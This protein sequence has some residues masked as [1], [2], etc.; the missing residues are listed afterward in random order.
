MTDL[1]SWLEEWVEV[2]PDWRISSSAVEL[3]FGSGSPSLTIRGKELANWMDGQLPR[4]AG[5]TYVAHCGIE[6]PGFAEYLIDVEH[7]GQWDRESPLTFKVGKTTV[8]LSAISAGVAALLEP[9]Y[10]YKH[11]YQ[12]EFYENYST[13]QLLGSQSP[14]VDAVA[15]LYY[16]NSDYLR[17][18]KASATIVHLVDPK[19]P[20]PWEA[21]QPR[22]I[23]RYRIRTRPQLAALI[24]G[25]LYVGAAAEYGDARFLG[26]YRVLEF[27]F[28]R[29]RVA[30]LSRARRDF[31]VSDEAFLKSV[32]DLHGELAEL[33]SLLRSVLSS[34]ECG[35]LCRYLSHHR[36]ANCSTAD[37]LAK[38][39]YAHRNALVHA[40]ENRSE[41]KVVP[42]LFAPNKSTERWSWVVE[43]LADR[44]IRKLGTVRAL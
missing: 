1:A 29:A 17:A 20:A 27:F 7:L 26:F 19:E 12:Y 42:D 3:S 35:K 16:L 28:N 25:Q 34:A 22:P 23:R 18:A 14:R 10:R 21:F 15:A 32:R 33:S 11:A 24:P 6:L 5:L 30:E 36:L 31:S 40:K 43:F 8:R 38:A 39:L 37:D 13:I 9:Y 4:T 41:R 2:P 44:A